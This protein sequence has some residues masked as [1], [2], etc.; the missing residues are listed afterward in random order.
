[1]WS[2]VFRQKLKAHNYSNLRLLLLSFSLGKLVRCKGW[3]GLRSLTTYC[4]YLLLNWTLCAVSCRK[5]TEG[6]D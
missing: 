5:K 6:L 2:G 1:M 3:R 4:L